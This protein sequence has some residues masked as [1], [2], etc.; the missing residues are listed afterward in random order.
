M[1]LII[2]SSFKSE[3][4]PILNWVLHL[5]T[6]APRFVHVSQW[7]ERCVGSSKGS[8]EDTCVV[9]GKVFSTQ[10]PTMIPMKPVSSIATTT[11]NVSQANVDWSK[12]Q[13]KGISIG[14]GG[15]SSAIIKTTSTIDRK[16]KG[17][18]IHVDPSIEEK[19]TEQEVEIER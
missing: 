16:D 11:T 14:K 7:G 12:L 19:K 9:V 5:P 2:K 17:K 8:G 6:N 15:S 4:A 1:L 10:I 3:L 13:K 18:G